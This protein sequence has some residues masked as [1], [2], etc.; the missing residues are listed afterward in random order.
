MRLAALRIWWQHR[1]T[2]HHLEPLWTVLHQQFPEDTLDRVPSSRWPDT[3]SLR[4]VHR[5]YYRRVIECRD[6]LVRISP[7]LQTAGNGHDAPLAEQLR[8]ALQARASGI[9]APTQA[10]PVAIPTTDDSLDADVHELI[11]LSAALR[12]PQP[13]PSPR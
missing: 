6:G 4:G 12:Q 7:Y 9:A 13:T 2:Y 5:R 1:R 3:L 8:N 10:I 11:T